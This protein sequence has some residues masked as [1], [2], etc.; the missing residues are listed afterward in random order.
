MRISVTLLLDDAGKL[1]TASPALIAKYERGDPDFREATLLWLNEAERVLGKYS[2]PQVAG[3]SALKGKL[4]AATNGIV[5]KSYLVLPGSVQNRRKTQRAVS[6]LIFNQAQE[7]IV[8]L[9][10]DMSEKRTEALKYL[11]QMVMLMEQQNL[12]PVTKGVSR[13]QVLARLFASM[14]SNPGSMAA[15][16]HVLSLVNLADALRLLDEILTEWEIAT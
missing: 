8:G 4:L 15:A 2:L 12:L 16:R 6:A 7:L 1:L 14:R 10:A 11:R 3:I 5:E 13:S 9:H